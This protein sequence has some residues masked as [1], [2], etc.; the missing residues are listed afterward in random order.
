MGAV[1]HRE[2]RSS[3]SLHHQL[4]PWLPLHLDSKGWILLCS[5]VP[6]THTFPPQQ[7]PGSQSHIHHY[8][9][10]QDPPSRAFTHNASFVTAQLS[11]H[12]FSFF[13]QP[14][15][16]REPRTVKLHSKCTQVPPWMV[17][18][19]QMVNLNS[20]KTPN[21]RKENHFKKEKTLQ[22]P[23]LQFQSSWT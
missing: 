19:P 15:P 12:Y 5:L 2:I 16:Q 1:S 10:S 8:S 3:F 6:Q 13:S 21:L 7:S 14:C 4:P 20:K 18:R 11:D 22:G 23:Q 9:S 17:K